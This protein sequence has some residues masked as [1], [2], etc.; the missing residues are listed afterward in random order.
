MR[1]GEGKVNDVEGE[2]VVLSGFGG[3]V[4]RGGVLGLLGDAGW[5]KNG[6]MVRWEGGGSEGGALLRLEEEG[7]LESLCADLFLEAG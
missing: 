5:V 4:G 7:G 2:F 1:E 6:W 3:P